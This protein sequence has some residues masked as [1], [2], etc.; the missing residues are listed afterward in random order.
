MSLRHAVRSLKRTPA[1]TVAAIVTL[2]LGIAAAAA[3]F[4]VV[5]GVL[6]APLPFGHPDRLVAIDLRAP[7]GR[8]IQQPSGVFLTYQRLAR[9]LADVAM[10][11]T[12]SANILGD[13]DSPDAERVQ[14]TWISASMLRTLGVSPIIGRAF[15]EEET[16]PSGPSA[17]IITEQMWRTR[18][19]GRADV[20]GKT[21]DVN[22]VQRIIV[23]VMPDRFHFP[24]PETRI[25]LPVRVD[26]TALGD[27]TYTLVGRLAG[28][29][30]SEQAQRDLASL[31][32]RVATDFP[33]LESGSSTA[34]WLD[35]VR[36]NPAVVSLR[37]AM[38]ADIARTLWMLAAAAGLVLLVSCAN[39]ANLMLIRA[40]GRQTELALRQ[41]LGASRMRVL[42]HFAGEAT[43][44]AAGAGALAVVIA[45]VA[46]RA[47]VAFGPPDIPR[48]G[49]L[50][51]DAA[52]LGFTLFLAAFAVVAC[53][54]IPTFR[55]RRSNL[56]FALREG[57]RHETSSKA[58]Q[59]LRAAIVSLQIAV[60][61]VVLAGSALLLRTFHRLYSEPP[62]FVSDHVAT[63]WL[64]LPFARYGDST[65]VAFFAR[66]TAEVATLPGVRAVGVT[67]TLPLGPGERMQRSFVLEDGR[68]VSLPTY[69]VNDGYFATLGVPL[70]T[71]SNFAPL[72]AQSAGEVIV[73]RRAAELLWKDSSVIGKR[74]GATVNGPWYTVI[75]V[76]GDA[77]DRDLA[78]P[79]PPLVYMPQAVP[80]DASH[81]IDPSARHTMAL[82][83]KTGADPASIVAP[84]RRI[85]R[86]ID[87]GVPTYDDQPMSDVV[88]ASTARLSFT[89]A[90]LS[91]AAVI[92]MLLG[93]VGLYG[94]TAYMVA[95]RTR[96]FGVRIALGAEP[97]RLVRTV[98]TRG[99]V[100]VGIG[101]G[102]GLVL[103]AIVGRFLRSFLYG[104]AP[105]DPLTLLGATLAIVGIALLANWL[106]A[107][108]AGQVD[109]AIA[110]RAE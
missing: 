60:A 29:V 16:T 4:N 100:L 108:R 99:L 47:L 36:P 53:S 63:F 46:V 59:R 84:V 102:A 57:G 82:V 97:G 72:G 31:L 73:S 58:R 62:G 67:N 37:D 40:D 2:V 94:V 35:E 23:G 56:S 12:G 39:V 38:T 9:D 104:V 14:A 21:L 61:L 64:T 80:I 43:V 68:E 45:W 110:L 101:V 17:A 13:E 86:G 88:R 81:V 89:L 7:D 105:N 96:E 98:A 70:V 11:R 83:V 41:A 49:E 5:Y 76:A 8:L 44:L 27:F 79:A 71:G 10:Y 18:F 33:R 30:T 26:A 95:L 22:R 75:G 107:R 19:G 90:L 15:T 103:F 69:V 78:T 52:T 28:G 77:R 51:M 34:S 66:L 54:V 87:A 3:M 109:P 42:T 48:L 55:L 92:T 32:P 24:S 85:L 74:F 6:L 65:T 93:A 25:W 1:F 20:L 50:H 106:P 91:I